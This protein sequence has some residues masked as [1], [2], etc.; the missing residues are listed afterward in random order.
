VARQAPRSGRG[1][2]DPI[3]IAPRVRLP[4]SLSPFPPTL[5]DHHGFQALRRVSLP[6]LF[7][8]R[9]RGRVSTLA[10]VR[11][12]DGARR[13]RADLR[14]DGAAATNTSAHDRARRNLSWNTTDDTLRQVRHL[15]VP[16]QSPLLTQSSQAFGS[17]GNVTDVRIR[18]LAP[19]DAY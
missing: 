8:L 10:R 16:A 1:F 6:L 13:D 18:T 3:D 11:C 19:C 15:H 2:L 9:P 7:S 5:P 14:A 4:T 12:A 17:F